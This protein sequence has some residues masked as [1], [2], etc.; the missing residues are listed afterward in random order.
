MK[1][2]LTLTFFISSLTFCYTQPI[3]QKIHGGPG[4]DEP[5]AA[6]KTPDGGLIIFGN[7]SSIG[8]IDRNF[9]LMKIN[10]VG[11]ISW[12]KAYNGDSIDYGSYI[13]L[14]ADGGY[15]LTGSFYKPDGTMDRHKQNVRYR[16][17]VCPPL[18]RAE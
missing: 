18:C 1:K 6:Q 3:Y 16:T 11:D 5:A 13:N 12:S 7:T 8:P 9:Y 15:I 14:T 17:W 2:I 10:S 4:R